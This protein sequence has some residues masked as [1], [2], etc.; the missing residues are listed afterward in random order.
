G[1]TASPRQDLSPDVIRVPGGVSFMGTHAGEIGHDGE[2]PERAT[3][4]A[5]FGLEATT[6]TNERFAAFVTATGYVTEAERFG[7]SAVFDNDEAAMASARR[8]GSGLPWWHRVEGVSWREP[9]GPGSSIADR[10][11]HPVVQVSWNDANA[12]AGWDGG[13]LPTEAEWEHA[14]RGGA[15]RKRF[16]WGDQEPDDEDAIL[17]NI[18]QGR[19]PDRNTARDGYLRKIGRAAC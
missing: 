14:A 7:W 12:F 1:M 2:E 10:M 15:V 11:D 13:R 19:F 6:V 4:L 9:E 16:P 18:W 17:C 5:D 3:K 8:Q